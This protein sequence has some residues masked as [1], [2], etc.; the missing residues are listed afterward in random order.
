MRHEGEVNVA[1]FGPD[2]MRIITASR[3]RT[4]RVW[5]AATGEPLTEPMR[6]DNR[7]NAA[8]FSPDG[9][10]VVTGSADG[11]ARVWDLPAAL[12][13]AWAADLAEAIAGYRLSDQGVVEPLTDHYER[14][15]ELQRRAIEAAGD[16]HW[17]ALLRWL[18]AP[19][20]E[21]TISPLSSLTV[22][23]FVERRLA[24]GS[25]ASLR[26]ALAADPLNP[27]AR[28]R[29]AELQASEG[30]APPR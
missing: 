12:A 28:R 17:T 25:E 26:E 14:R 27:E 13:P 22:R 24:E 11:T 7:V 2:G 10:R 15:V 6:H 20:A 30:E 3:D 1:A 16:D 19:P 18:F 5:D 9:S 23:E 8:A 29:L 21:R 4:A